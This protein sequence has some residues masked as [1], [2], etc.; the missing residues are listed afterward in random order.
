ME[1]LGHTKSGF[2]RNQM[3]AQEATAVLLQRNFLLLDEKSYKRFITALD[4]LKTDLPAPGG[5]QKTLEAIITSVRLVS[6]PAHL[7]TKH[8]VT[9]FNSGVADL[10]NW[11]KKSALAHQETGRSQT[12]VACREGDR[13]V[14][15]YALGN[16]AV[17]QGT[18]TGRGWDNMPAPVPVMVLGR[19]A[20]DRAW[21]GRGIGRGLL[22]HVMLKTLHER[23][24]I[25]PILVQAITEHAKRFYE[26]CGFTA[27]SIEPMT[28]MAMM[29]DS[30]R[31][32]LWK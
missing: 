21:Q 20:V 28:L 27:S 19:L 32:L 23:D 31:P 7:S 22:R 14:G 16:G 11:L 24:D 15:Y 9:T 30:V 25:Q 12:Y 26:H 3:T 18:A 4:E 2:V 5:I 10:D 17:A 13:V 8:N 1:A 6:A 29:T